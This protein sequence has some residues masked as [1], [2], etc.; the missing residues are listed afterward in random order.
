MAVSQFGDVKEMMETNQT[1]ED[2]L[3]DYYG[4]K[5][6]FLGVVATVAVGFAVLF[7]FVFALSIKILNFQRR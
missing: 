3:R 4:F 5:H 1:V 7:A 2:F 6:E